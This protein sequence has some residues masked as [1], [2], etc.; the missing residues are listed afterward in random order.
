MAAKHEAEAF[1]VLLGLAKAQLDNIAVRADVI[2]AAAL[3][4]GPIAAQLSRLIRGW[5]GIKNQSAPLPAILPSKLGRLIAH[6]SE[7]GEEKEAADLARSLL[8]LHPEMD[9]GQIIWEG[10]IPR[11]KPKPRCDPMEYEEVLD[12]DIPVLVR[13]FPDAGLRLLVRLLATALRFS[14]PDGAT[15]YQDHSNAW[16]PSIADSPQ[17]VEYHSDV[18]EMLVTALRN[19]VEQ[20]VTAGSVSLPEAIDILTAQDRP[21]LARIAMNALAAHGG[22]AP[23][24][25]DEWLT[26]EDMFDGSEVHHEYAELL[27]RHFSILPDESKTTVLNWI[28]AGPEASASEESAEQALAYAEQWRLRRLAL[29]GDSLT[30]EWRTTFDD[31][32]AKYGTPEHPDFLSFATWQVGD[33][34]PMDSGALGAMSVEQV[35]DTARNWRPTQGGIASPSVE[36]LARSISAVATEQPDAFSAQAAEFVGL[37]PPYIRNLMW[38]LREVAAKGTTLDWGPV[39]E[40]CVWC[41]EQPRD[42]GGPANL[43][44]MNDPNWGWTF[45]SIGHLLYVGLDEGRAEIPISRREDVW[46][47]LEALLKD[48]EPT[49]AGNGDGGPHSMSLNTVRGQAMHALVK[50]AFWVRRHL[51]ETGQGDAPGNGGGMPEVWATL[52]AHLDVDVDIS[53]VIRAVYGQWFPWLIT[54][55]AEWASRNVKRIFPAAG[56]D[57]YWAAAWNTYV[58][59]NSAY[60]AA[61]ERLGYAYSRAIDSLA[62]DT[63]PEGGLGDPREGLARH[64]IAFVWQGNLTLEDEVAARFFDVAPS[65][66]RAHAIGYAGRVMLNTTNPVPEEVIDRLRLLWEARLALLTALGQVDSAKAELEAFGWW[67]YAGRFPPAWALAQLVWVLER[68]H[69]VEMP[70]SVV[71]RLAAIANVYPADAA[72]CISLLIQ[73][74]PSYWEV[75]HWTADAKVVLTAALSSGDAGGI[76][77]ANRAI[78][79]LARRGH[80]GFRDLLPGL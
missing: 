76:E 11:P 49:D 30:D 62:E 45:G 12:K 64:V 75:R 40:L 43:V 2:E 74:E 18:T 16:R 13:H 34:S 29:I 79:E 58:T 37:P 55:N 32:C 59:T 21:L 25:V 72:K 3:L 54:L 56:D 5:P 6:L 68:F 77:E 20:A 51:V 80:M 47:I 33:V 52:D 22:D 1:P 35:V 44:G 67:F 14:R 26:R 10:E 57:R 24:L 27:R 70:S 53:A 66:L 71:E 69:S 4:P 65:P 39:L 41:V 73:G 50:Y 19:A 7:S 36:G 61:L 31:L 17:N 38:S 63:E 28:G 8:A 9:A 78:N 15:D 48:P 46:Q 23:E 42:A 60:S